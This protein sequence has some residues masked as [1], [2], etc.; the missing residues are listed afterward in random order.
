V[1]EVGF[2][3]RTCDD[4]YLMSTSSVHLRLQAITHV[5]VSSALQLGEGRATSLEALTP[6][7]SL[8]HT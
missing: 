3:G 2:A 1:S 8:S 4:E 5:L 6:L 7:L